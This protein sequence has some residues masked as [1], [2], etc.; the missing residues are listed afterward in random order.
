MLYEI[1]AALSDPP[2]LGDLLE[3]CV[4]AF[5]Y[6]QGR[7]R[8]VLFCLTDFKQWHYLNLT[9]DGNRL[10]V[11]GYRNV[12]YSSLVPKPKEQSDHLDFLVEYVQKNI[13]VYTC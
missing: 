5:Y 13:E 8:Y 9:R 10:K 11:S 6:L 2:C 7:E 4:Q 12:Q 1:K 3:S